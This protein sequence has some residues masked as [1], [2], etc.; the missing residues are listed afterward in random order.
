MDVY[1]CAYRHIIYT[2]MYIAIEINNPT[3]PLIPYLPTELSTL[4]A[5]L[6]Q[7][8]V[9]AMTEFLHTGTNHSALHSLDP[10]P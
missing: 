3:I 9:G 5:K 1:V 7:A 4:P 8:A 2:C 10:Y 6:Y